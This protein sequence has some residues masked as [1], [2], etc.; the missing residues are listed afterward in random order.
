MKEHLL[1][2]HSVP[3]RV[4]GRARKLH[5]SLR[6]GALAPL[7]VSGVLACGNSSS[8]TTG[9]TPPSSGGTGQ[10]SGGSAGTGNTGNPSG[11]SAGTGTSGGSGTTGTAGTGTS[12]AAGTGTAGAA[13]TGTA[14]AAG[15][16]TAGAAGTGAAG[17]AGAPTT[18][19]SVLERNNHPSRDALFVQPT[20]TTAVAKT[21]ASDTGFAATFTGSMWA[22]PLYMSNGPNG[23]GAFFA[24]TTGNDVIALDETTGAALWTHNI[25]PSPTANGVNCGSIHPLGILGTPVIDAAS[26]TIFV[27][28]AI[29]PSATTL[30]SIA[31]HEVHALNIDTGMERTGWPVDVT[32]LKSGNTTFQPQPANQRSALSLV[33]GIVYVAYGGHIGDCGD[34]NGWVVAINAT[35]PTK[36]GAWATLGQGEGIWAAGG[37]ASDGTAVF[38][39]TGNSKA[40]AEPADRSTSDAEEAVRITGLGAFTRSNANLFFP[41]TWKTMDTYDAD[42]GASN[43]VY[44]TVP[45]AT[46]ANYVAVLAK[47]GVIYYLN[48]QNLGGM[49][50]Q[51][52]K[53]TAASATN[54]HMLIHTSPTV[55]TTSKG[56]H[57]AFTTDAGAACPAGS[58][59]TGKVVMSVVITAGTDGKPATTA[60]WCAPL[61]G[62]VTAPIA[63]STDGSTN[64]I[65]WYMNNN[66]LAAVDGDTG[67]AIYTSTDSCANVRQ[68]TSPIAVKG[69]IVTS[70]DGK[71]CS[72]SAH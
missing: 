50:G 9:G 51:V 46:P 60:A 65:V 22:S 64:A 53:F 48:S 49:D 56:L 26:R 38:A 11:G 40:P 39:L 44:L 3:V 7:L 14:G 35:D 63:T 47:D 54:N 61:G 67:A 30:T 31:R 62:T 41:S 1:S 71:L 10:T 42:L 69:R 72:W 17:A 27:D 15:T 33:N 2:Q 52:A 5:T 55:Y 43:P 58:A 28:G 36:T 37:M 59:A 24:V 19:G 25:G 68:W 13:G 57:L 12:G 16:G 23:K 45:G 18:D 8:G 6:Y 70:A 4:G 21:M 32:K 29:A 66:K 20:L 34:Y